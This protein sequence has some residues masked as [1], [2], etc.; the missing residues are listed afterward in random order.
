MARHLPITTLLLGLL[1]QWPAVAYDGLWWWDPQRAGQGVA[2][3]RQCGRYLGAVYYYDEAGQGRWATFSGPEDNLGFRG[4]LLSFTGPPLGS[5]WKATPVTPGVAG[6]LEVEFLGAEKATFSYRVGSHDATLNLVPFPVGNGSPGIYDGIWWDSATPGQAVML[7]HD[8]DSLSGAWYLY[9]SA[10]KGIWAVFNGTLSGDC[11]TVDLTS[12]TGPPADQAWN[13]ALL[14]PLA[15][16]SGKL[17]FPSDDQASFYYRIG[18][19]GG[20]LNLTPFPVACPEYTVEERSVHAQ[21]NAH[22]L[23]I[24]KKA[25]SWSES[26][27]E[28]CRRHSQDMAEGKVAF[29]HDGFSDRAAAID[30][31]IGWSSVAEN[32]AYNQ[33]Y[34]D[35][36]GS[37]VTGLLNSPGHRANIEG[38]FDT[39]GIGVAVTPN[40]RYYFTQIFVKT[41]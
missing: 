24:G 1:A 8:G 26:V 27:A 33:G 23:G 20:R 29:G 31:I 30:P 28:I 40:G 19:A 17:C 14:S 4:D 7:A 25:L 38:D 15:K 36:A 13:N 12:F 2:M 10:G 6:S 35:P 16:G 41:P 5:D 39:T 9:D 21:V 3:L 34:A 22:R 11:V 32:V 37:A 18:N